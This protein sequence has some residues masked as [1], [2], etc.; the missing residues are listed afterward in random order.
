[1]IVADGG[2]VQLTARAADGIVQNLVQAGGKIRAATMGDQTGTVAL[3]GIGGSIVVEGQLS[4][5][6]TAPGTTGGAIEVVT[7]GNVDARGDGEDQRVGQGRRR[8]GGDRHDAGAGQGRAGRHIGADGDEC[9]GA[10][11]CNDRG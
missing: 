10:A 11:G 5:P 2:T 7:N 4:A 1:M 3:N 6:G 8:H 9:H